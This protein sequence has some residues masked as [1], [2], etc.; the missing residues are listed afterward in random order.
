MQH[1]P[2]CLYF[3]LSIGTSDSV[4]L[5]HQDNGDRWMNPVAMTIINPRKE[6]W[7]SWRSNQRPPVLKSAMLLTELWGSGIFRW[8][9]FLKLWQE[10]ENTVGKGYLC[11][12]LFPQG[13]KVESVI[14]SLKHRTV[15][16]QDNPF[17]NK[18][19]FLRVYSVSL[20]KTL[21][22]KDK[23]LVTSNLSFSY[24]VLNPFG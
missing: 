17:P 18:H 8:P 5:I 11:F 13:F 15:W 22:E 4:A 24:S 12:L 3:V 16:W 21:W 9:I 14:W 2:K 7:S 23:L 19:W 1:Y 6:Y 10:V 20:L